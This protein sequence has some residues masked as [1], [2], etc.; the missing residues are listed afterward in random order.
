MPKQ[1]NISLRKKKKKRTLH[2]IFT[3][4]KRQ[5]FG[6]FKSYKRG[7]ENIKN[8][9]D[10]YRILSHFLQIQFYIFTRRVFEGNYYQQ[11]K[12]SLE[13]NVKVIRSIQ[14]RWNLDISKQ[15]FLITNTNLY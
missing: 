12:L 1:G 8:F 13:Q 3:M 4:N 11:E 9:K 7:L 6:I 10:V 5:F 2:H 14:N 15:Y